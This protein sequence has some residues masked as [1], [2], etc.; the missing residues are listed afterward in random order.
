MEETKREKRYGH[1]IFR[2]WCKQCGICVAFCPKK[3]LDR[4][5]KGA[6]VV[7]RPQ[8]C[9]GCRFCELH[10]P[11]FAISITEKDQRN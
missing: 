1:T 6:P 5:P 2:D 8:D 3:V 11:D 10:C 9:I 4:D 7:A